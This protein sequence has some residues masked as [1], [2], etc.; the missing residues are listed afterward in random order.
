MTTAGAEDY[1]GSENLEVM[2]DA[3]NYNNYLKSLVREHADDSTHSLDFGAGIGT[4]S[5]SLAVDP[6]TMSCVEPDVAAQEVLRTAG[7]Q[8][9]TDV[10][11][12]PSG[13]L[14]YIFSLNVLEHIEDD[15]AMVGALRNA[16]Q[17]GGSIFVYVPA[18]NVLRTS[19]DDVVGHHRRYN[20]RQLINLFAHAGFKVEKAAYTDPAGYFAALAVKFMEL[21]QSEP[22]GQLNRNLVIAYDRVAFPIS[23]LMAVLFGRLF[24]KNVYIHARKI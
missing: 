24:G 3:V 8:V 22:S 7:Y 15:A 12:I 19:M 6:A 16:L 13:S 14:T 18:F 17:P 9:Y 20:R 1:S 5:D 4:F 21:F 11:E 2:L 10:S 23:R